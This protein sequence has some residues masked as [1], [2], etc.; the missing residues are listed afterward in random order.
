M[1]QQNP[2]PVISY[3]A[4]PRGQSAV[5]LFLHRNTR[6]RGIMYNRPHSCRSIE[7]LL[8]VRALSGLFS[9]TET[10]EHMEV[11]TTEPHS[12]RLWLCLWPYRASPR[13]QSSVRLFHTEMQGCRS[14]QCCN[15]GYCLFLNELGDLMFMWSTSKS[16]PAAHDKPNTVQL[17]YRERNSLHH[18]QSRYTDHIDRQ[19]YVF[20]IFTQSLIWAH[21]NNSNIV[22]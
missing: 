12:C 15:D 17:H 18:H 1:L 13:G 5:S 20:I 9:A 7:L 8:E 6:N 22:T 14:I 2:T 4:S 21:L 11:C 3:R 16:V 19:K 10:Q